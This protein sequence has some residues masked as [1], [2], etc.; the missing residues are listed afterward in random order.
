M[1]IA[2][3]DIK[4][5]LLLELYTHWC[6]GRFGGY[7]QPSPTV[8]GAFEN[9]LRGTILSDSPSTDPVHEAWKQYLGGV[10]Q[11]P[12]LVAPTPAAPPIPDESTDPGSPTRRRPRAASSS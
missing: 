7:Q 8:M 5:R 6:Q 1:T 11:P 12:D 10:N 4:G 2:M 9:Y 3:E